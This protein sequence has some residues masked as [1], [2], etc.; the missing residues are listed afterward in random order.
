MASGQRRICLCSPTG[1]GK[2]KMMVQ[3]AEDAL[4]EG[5]RVLQLASRKWLLDQLYKGLTCDGFDVRQMRSGIKDVGPRDYTLASIPTL[6][7]RDL[8]PEA[9]IVLVDEAHMD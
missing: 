8:M 4:R 1:G 9:D 7:A 3:L 6:A 5:K 2:S